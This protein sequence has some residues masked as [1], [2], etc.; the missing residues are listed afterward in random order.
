MPCEQETAEVDYQLLTPYTPKALKDRAVVG[1]K[2]NNVPRAHVHILCG[3]ST[4][5][6]SVALFRAEKAA[7]LGGQTDHC[8]AVI[9]MLNE[10]V[11][12]CENSTKSHI[13]D[14]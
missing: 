10:K 11:N 3:S 12:S 1:L 2:A 4:F 8:L 14:I 7:V 9:M 6:H 13:V 5:S